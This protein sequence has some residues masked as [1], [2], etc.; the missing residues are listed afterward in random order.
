MM[1]HHIDQLTIHSLRRLRDLDLPQLGNMNLLVGPNNSGKTTVLEA[2]AL[3][4]RPLDP[5]EWLAVARRR[6]IPSSQRS[7]LECVRWLFPQNTADLDNPYYEGQIRIAGQGHFPCAEADAS[8]QGFGVAGEQSRPLEYEHVKESSSVRYEDEQDEADAA[9]GGMV[10]GADITLSAR[11]PS[12]RWSDFDAAASEGR[13]VQQFRMVED[14]RFIRR[15]PPHGPRLPV[16]TV[17]PFSHRVEPLPIRPYSETTWT[18]YEPMFL[19]CVKLID[20]EVIEL[21]IL[22]RRG[23]PPALWLR[24]AAA[25]HVPLQAMGD[26]VR[27]VLT[28]ALALIEARRG[29]LLIDEIETAI[30]KEALIPVFR[31]L[32]CAAVDLEVQV[33]ATTQSLEAVDAIL[34]AKLDDLAELVAYRLPSDGETGTKRFP[35]DLLENLRFD[36]GLDIR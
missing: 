26:G 4:C 23:D 20:P 28:L 33:F 29:V 8:F 15:Q 25:G 13:L 9:A 14:E 10:R 5:L 3:F 31:W 21:Q 34:T 35:G 12:D 16:A 27:R 19:E 32:A 11:V 2:V 24:H 7:L 22:S 18:Q 1:A 36:R 30:H 6:A 17:T